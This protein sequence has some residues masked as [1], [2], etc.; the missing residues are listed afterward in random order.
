VGR[1]SCPSTKRTTRSMKLPPKGSI[2]SFSQLGSLATSS[3]NEPSRAKRSET[4]VR[5]RSCAAAGEAA[6]NSITTDNQRKEREDRKKSNSLCDLCG[7]CVDIVSDVPVTGGIIRAMTTMAFLTVVALGAQ[8]APPTPKVEIVSVTGC[9]KEASAN[10][11]T[12]VSATDPV[13]SNA[14]AP[15]AKDIPA[16]PPAGKNEYRLIGVSE[17]NLPSHK[18]HTVVVKGLFLKATPTS[19]INVTSVT[20]VA[21]TCVPAGGK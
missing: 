5:S 21:A 11:W 1:I 10:T 16:T 2:R 3:V 14:N 12:L 19:R 7:L 17:F 9:L 6:D 8:A 20:M 18:D 15:A 4:C 13:P